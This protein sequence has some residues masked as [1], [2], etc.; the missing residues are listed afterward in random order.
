MMARFKLLLGLVAAAAAAVYYYVTI[1]A[2]N[3]HSS[4][5]W[6]FIISLAMVF[7]T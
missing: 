2:L 4:G 7:K 6:M 5:F 3:I 1:P